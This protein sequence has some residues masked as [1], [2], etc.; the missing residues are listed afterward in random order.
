MHFKKGELGNPAGRLKRAQDLK[1]RA[2]L[3]VMEEEQ[4]DPVRVMAKIAADERADIT[5]RFQVCEQLAQYLHLKRK[6]VEVFGDLPRCRCSGLHSSD[7]I[8]G[9]GA[10]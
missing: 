10:V 1:N 7:R 2:I 6:V 3:K 9:T 5:F 8:T 4:C